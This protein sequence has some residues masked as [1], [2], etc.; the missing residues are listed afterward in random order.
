MVTIPTPENWEQIIE[1]T[2]S[3]R[4]GFDEIRKAR[5]EQELAQKAMMQFLE[6]CKFENC[7]PN[8]GYIKAM[9][10]NP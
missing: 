8:E 9:G 6:N 2:Q 3:S 4:A 7:T 1:F 10:M 5:P